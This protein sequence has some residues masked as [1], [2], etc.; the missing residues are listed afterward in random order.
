MAR[1]KEKFKS[2]IKGGF[3]AITFEMINSKAYKELRGSAIKALILCMKKVK[4]MHCTER[5]KTNFSLTYPEARKQGFCDATFWRAMRLL[6]HVGFIDCVM[7]GGLR[8]DRKT[9]STYRLSLR[10]KV[11]GTPEFK[12]LPP[13]HCEDINGNEPF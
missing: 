7:K 12:C 4:E 13:G 2:W 3:V 10:W 9:P 8:C 1:K 6:Q 5:F 11:Y